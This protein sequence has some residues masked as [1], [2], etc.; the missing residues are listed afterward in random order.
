MS[1]ADR[2]SRFLPSIFGQVGGDSQE[3]SDP[4]RSAEGYLADL[5]ADLERKADELRA[6]KAHVQAEYDRVMADIDRQLKPVEASIASLSGTAE[7]ARATSSDKPRPSKKP[8]A[9][10]RKPPSNVGR[11]R[12]NGT[13]TGYGVT[14]EGIAPVVEQCRLFARRGEHFTQKEVYKAL[15]WDQS[16]GSA[17]FKA[18]REIQFLRK[19]G[20]KGRSVAWAILDDDA[21]D[22]VMAQIKAGGE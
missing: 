5:K 16:R 2:G 10:K 20:A 7:P 3:G 6:H 12:K 17:A 1:D 11:T 18:L 8:A 14:W 9:K 15:D 19:A 13:A 22:K 4:P 21:Y